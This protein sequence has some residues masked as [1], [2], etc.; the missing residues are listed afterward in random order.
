MVFATKTDSNNGGYLTQQF[1]KVTF[2]EIKK[3]THDAK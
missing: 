3:N 2:F 1:L